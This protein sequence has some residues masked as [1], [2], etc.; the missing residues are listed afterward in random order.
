MSDRFDEIDRWLHPE[1]TSPDRIQ[2]DP[3][4]GDPLLAPPPP[5]APDAE[6]P[7]LSADT[8]AGS[9]DFDLGTGDDRYAAVGVRRRLVLGGALALVSLVLLLLLLLTGPST[10]SASDGADL[11]APQAADPEFIDRGPVGPPPAFADPAPFA[12]APPPQ[13][14]VTPSSP[15]YTPGTYTTAPVHDAPPPVQVA[16]QPAPEPFDPRR[17]AYEAATASPLMVDPSGRELSVGGQTAAAG[18]SGA[19]PYA[20]PAAAAPARAAPAGRTAEQQAAFDALSP[21]AQAAVEETRLM[22][23][24]LGID[25]NTTTAPGTS[26]EAATSPAAS[27]AVAPASAPE[28]DDVPAS[29]TSTREAILDRV[30]RPPPSSEPFRVEASPRSTGLRSTPSARPLVRRTTDQR[31]PSAGDPLPAPPPPDDPAP[32]ETESL[33]KVSASEEEA[34]EAVAPGAVATDLRLLPGTVIPAVLVTGGWFDAQDLYGPLKTYASVAAHN[35]T[36]SYLAMG[37]WWHGAWAR[38]DGERYGDLYFGQQTAV[39]YRENV[40]APFFDAYLKG[41][42]EP[43][44][45]KASVFVTGANRWRFFDAWPPRAARAASLYLQPGGGLGF[46]APTEAGAFE[47]YVSDPAKPVP[48]TDQIVIRRDD[49]FVVQDQRFASTRPDVLVFESPVLEEDVTLA[50]ELFA[51][52]FVTTTGTDADFVVK[53]IDVYPGDY[54]CRLPDASCSVPMGGFQQL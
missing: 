25:P 28:A 3:L 43:D 50:G 46:D 12:Y 20:V 21:D 5:E 53:L 17:E 41:N 47:E 18:A 34:P 33:P 42:G 45:A 19:G 35:A 9:R 2:D 36:P 52:L 16:A 7:D 10:P 4:A 29:G 40:Q 39:W 11:V 38:S 23:L 8:S 14:V 44:L 49:A 6:R 24:A 31:G 1:R 26:L 22:M 37:P 32:S 27:A 15:A 30:R 48:H 13:P 54:E 51:S